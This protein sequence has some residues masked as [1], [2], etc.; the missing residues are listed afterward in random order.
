M[1]GVAGC[2]APP[3]CV[4]VCL[5]R[6]WESYGRVSNDPVL[7]HHDDSPADAFGLKE[8]AR[9]AF[10]S[11]KSAFFLVSRGTWT[12]QR[13]PNLR[14]LPTPSARPVKASQ[15]VGTPFEVFMIT[16]AA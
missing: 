11:V 12:I 1:A 3:L 15:A 5:G 2:V 9:L 6:H 14:K 10:I 16:T 4:V 13:S 7:V 8:N